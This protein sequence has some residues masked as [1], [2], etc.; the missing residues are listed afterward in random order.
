MAATAVF[1]IGCL[2]PGFTSAATQGQVGTSSTGTILISV[3][4]PKLARV[5]KLEDIQL[6]T[7]TGTG[8]LTGNANQICVWT[9]SGTYSV[10]AQS[11]N[12]EGDQFNLKA[13]DGGTLSYSVAWAQ[14]GNQTSGQTLSPNSP[15]TGQ[16]T[17]A[18]SSD[19]SQGPSST[20]GLFVQVSE[21]ALSSVPD[22]SYSD[23]L[24][25]VITPL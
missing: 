2:T 16:S 19:C 14:S 20:A 11:E 4:V 9:N 25:L 3:A 12:T 1:A 6:G 21:D 5:S 24:T 10:T 17:N 22:G 7:W 23:T 13:S 8:D 15:L 18:T